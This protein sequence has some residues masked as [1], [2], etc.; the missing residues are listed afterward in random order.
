MFCGALR[1]RFIGEGCWQGWDGSCQK[2]VG[3]AVGDGTADG[4]R[5]N[6]VRH[7][8][9]TEPPGTRADLCERVYMRLYIWERLRPCAPTCTA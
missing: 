2:A 7:N 5:V 3:S 8:Y 4:R 1:R 9:A 6:R